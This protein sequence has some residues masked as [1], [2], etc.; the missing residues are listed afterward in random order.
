MDMF[1]VHLDP[2]RKQPL[3][4]Q[5]Y[6]H[7][8]REIEAGHLSYGTRLPSKRKLAGYLRISQNTLEAAYQQLVAEGYVEAVPKRG[9]FV[10]K[11]DEVLR[12]GAETPVSTVRTPSTGTE[13]F[14]PRYDFSP[15]SIDLDVF[16]FSIW[17]KLAKETI[18][19]EHKS[20]LQ[21]GHPQGDERLRSTI[22]QYLYYSRGVS[23]TPEQIIVGAG[24]E[25][26]FQLLLQI[27]GR[28]NSFAVENPGYYRMY[29]ILRSYGIDVQLLPLDEEGVDVA[30]LADGR[31]N[32]VYT[33]PS[34]QFPMG[35]VM[36]VNRRMRLLQWVNEQEGRYIIEDDYD[37]EFRY[38]GKPIPSLHGMDS[39]GKVIYIGTLSK[40]LSP[41]LRISYMV[42]PGRLLEIYR[43]HYISYASTVSRIDQH[44]LYRFIKEGYFEKHLNKMRRIYKRKRDR[45]V[46]A[47]RKFPEPVDIIGENAGLHLL[48]KVRNGL[49]EEELVSRAKEAGVKVYGISGYCFEPVPEGSDPVILLGFAGLSEEDIDAAAR[50]LEQA[51]FAIEP[52]SNKA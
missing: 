16:P 50:I 11:T 6:M 49:S 4:D 2:G 36:P 26:L 3:Y 46:A 14:V 7:I 31:S 44:V 27:L 13:A 18:Q 23:C 10:S 33:T 24:T 43:T 37:S 40:P 34:H 42:L 28:D 20:L 5:L 52:P 48:L 15:T 39:S 51:W 1:T 32:I 35:M 47:V 17:K 8:K 30:Q 41:S 21:L 25:S 29:R 19:F 45:L 22:S 9:F 12:I 38:S